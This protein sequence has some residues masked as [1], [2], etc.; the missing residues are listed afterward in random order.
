[1]A[2]S[3]SVLQTY[4]FILLPAIAA[5]SGSGEPFGWEICAD[6]EPDTT[7]KCFIRL[8]DQL[9]GDII[10]ICH[11]SGMEM[12]LN[13]TPMY[14]TLRY[15][16]NEHACSAE[17]QLEYKCSLRDDLIYH[18]VEACL[19]IQT[20]QQCRHCQ[21]LNLIE[22]IKPDAPFDLNITYQE[23]EGAYL[24][25]FSIPPS[26]QGYLKDSL[27]YEMAYW[28]EN[29]NWTMSSKTKLFQRVPLTLLR[30]EFQPS[31]K[32]ELKVRS[33]P[34]DSFFKGLW[35][36]WSSSAYIQ[37]AQRMPEEINNKII[38]MTTSFVAFFVL[39]VLIS[40]IPI[41]W[42]SRIKPF[43]WPA[44]PNHEKTLDKLCN[45]LR[46]NSEISFFNPESF[47]YAH[48]HKVDSIQAKSEMKHFQQ[49]LLPMDVP[50][51]AGNR[52]EL[53]TH[54]SH[55]NH[56]W[57]KLSLAYEGMW[58]AELLNRHLGRSCCI[59][60]DEFIKANLHNESGVGGQHGCNDAHSPHSSALLDPTILP[61]L[62]SCQPVYTN[63]QVKVAS[64]EEAYVTMASFF[65]SKGN[66]GN[67]I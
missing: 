56:G 67:Q 37:T 15:D 30:R 22:I 18:S 11:I 27:I 60:S 35:S 34:N 2:V 39:L 51:T 28:T 57:L 14:F 29:A 24:V 47:G 64:K 59:S 41:F 55:I 13:E 65:E 12:Y 42:K 7:F 46:K 4:F 48:I 58:P 5:E 32:Y 61:G 44:I 8:A 9:D 20:E 6:G 63:S 19:I 49:L 3:S 53:T 38:L 40:L 23:K 43:V 21:K 25:Q 66:P 33:K 52:L 1:M 45:K 10:L 17:N 16:D 50:E 31:T 54:L 62:E 26:S 36:E